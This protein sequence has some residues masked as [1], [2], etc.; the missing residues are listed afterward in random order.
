MPIMVYDNQDAVPEDVR[1]D[2]TE[3]KDG[4]NKGKWSINLVSRKSL[5]Q[6]RD[7]NVAI[8]EKHRLQGETVS[9]FKGLLGVADDADPDFTALETALAELR[10][11]EKGV[12]DGKLKKSDEIDA[13]VTKR[14]ELRS[15]Q[16]QA[17]LAE[18]NKK[19]GLVEQAKKDAD[20]ALDRT[21]IDRQVVDAAMA[22]K[23]GVH[24]S[25]VSDL[26]QQAYKVFKVEGA[27]KELRPYDHNGAQIYA[28]DGVTPRTVA[29]WVDF[30]AR[31]RWP[32]YFKQ[33]TGGG[34]AGG[35]GNK[36]FGG[37]SEAEFN[38][39][40]PE[41]RLARWNEANPAGGKK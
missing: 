2:A 22:E 28:L 9:K 29:E 16:Y 34:A 14:M 19:L 11:T 18:V 39:L 35:D 8:S 5:E 6:F 38:K 41:V 40:P 10:E 12:K 33:S 37:L 36:A 13:E 30:D 31:K 23:L 1:K 3:I 27:N 24:P 21:Y 32:H 7:N 15:S 20:L 4:D 26:I 25:A 17:S